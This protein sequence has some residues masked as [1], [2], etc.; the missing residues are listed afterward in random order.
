MPTA[1]QPDPLIKQL[2]G[3]HPVKTWSLIITFF[4]DAIV[5]RGG[6][7]SAATVQSLMTRLGVG[8]G[9][10]RTA[11]SRL[12]KDGWVEREKQGRNSFYSL[13]ATGYAPFLAA[14]ERIYAS[15][16]TE[17]IKA[18]A[19]P[20]K[21]EWLIAIRNPQVK[22][23]P[24][25]NELQAQYNGIRLTNNAVLFSATDTRMRKRLIDDDV[26]VL[27][28]TL[29]NTPGW[30][31]QLV[32]PVQVAARYHTLQQQFASLT[33]KPPY[34]PLTALATRCL[35]IHEWRRLLLRGTDL[36]NPLL[37]PDWPL[38]ECHH[39][40]AN[41]YQ[42]LTP[43]AEQWLDE[44]A[45]GPKGQLTSITDAMQHRFRAPQ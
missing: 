3:A 43:A 13:S 9:A 17:N 34:D 38:G 42:Q 27:T 24:L 31:Q 30:L 21:C 39:F 29:C 18:P 1:P 28:S 14:S 12:A 16:P 44:N 22:K 15:P 41:L 37:P 8:A 32:G 25:W 6:S 20:D 10:V 7:V 33:G 2:H 19:V 5:P 45:T 4:G 35:L 40:V 26:I 11:F 23:T 36:H